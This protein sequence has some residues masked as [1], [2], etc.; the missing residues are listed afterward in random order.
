[1]KNQRLLQCPVTV[2]KFDEM[3]IKSDAPSNTYT[4]F[5]DKKLE[6]GEV[7]TTIK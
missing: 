4:T 2:G 7:K 3:M 5:D 1:M 6:N